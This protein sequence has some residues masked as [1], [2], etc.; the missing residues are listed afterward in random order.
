MKKVAKLLGI[1]G[2]NIADDIS[3]FFEELIRPEMELEELAGIYSEPLDLIIEEETRRGNN[4]VG[5]EFKISCLSNDSFDLS[6][7][8]YFQNQD[9]QWIKREGRSKPQSMAYFTQKASAEVKEKES[10]SVE[11]DPPTEKPVK[12]PVEK[13]VTIRKKEE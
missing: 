5:G 6:F 1:T 2:K 4:Y 12:T 10:I 13:T 7:E 8:L 11:I 3:G 9:K